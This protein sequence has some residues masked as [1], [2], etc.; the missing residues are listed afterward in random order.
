MDKNWVKI[1][2]TKDAYKAEIYKGL[3]EENEIDVVLMNKQ[4]SAYLFGE[5]DIYVIAEH[6]IK[7]KHIITLH[8]ET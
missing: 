7:A 5:I 8:N 3:L 4:D 1:I 6:V 2:S